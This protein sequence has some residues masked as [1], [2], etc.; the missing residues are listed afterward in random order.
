MAE[1]LEMIET[2]ETVEAMQAE[3]LA[4]FVNPSTTGAGGWD[5]A[6]TYN[7]LVG[8]ATLVVGHDGQP[9]SWG[10]VDHWLSPEFHDLPIA[11]LNRI[12]WEC[13]RAIENSG[14][15]PAKMEADR[16]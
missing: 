2:P 1:D 4:E 9:A 14:V 10:D 12:E 8:E 5:V 11:A 7:N 6:V 15:D 16:G 13:K 3:C